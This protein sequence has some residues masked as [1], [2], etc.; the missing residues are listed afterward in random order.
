M[1][2]RKTGFGFISYSTYIHAKSN[3]KINPG[4]FVRPSQ[5]AE[6]PSAHFSLVENK[7]SGVLHLRRSKYGRKVWPMGSLHTLFIA[8]ICIWT[9]LQ[10]SGKNLGGDKCKNPGLSFTE[11]VRS[12]A[13]P[14]PL[15]AGHQLPWLQRASLTD[16]EE[17]GC[18][19]NASSFSSPFRVLTYLCGFEEVHQA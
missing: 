5:A 4:A 15:V 19:R 9:T 7:V 16:L 8:E 6:S 1:L 2:F 17:W 11:S 12:K 13:S 18:Y 14:N 3:S 10:R